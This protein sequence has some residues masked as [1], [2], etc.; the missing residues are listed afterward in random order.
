MKT[1]YTEGQPL[2]GNPYQYYKFGYG[3]GMKTLTYATKETMT[4]GLQGWV[5]WYH[6][7]V[8][9]DPVKD[10]AAQL[11]EFTIRQWDFQHKLN[12]NLP[13]NQAPLFNYD[14]SNVDSTMLPIALEATNVPLRDG[15]KVTP[16]TAFGWV[17][18]PHTVEQYQAAIAAFTSK[19][20]QNG[21][22]TYFGPNGLGWPTFYN[23]D[24]ASTGINI[25]AGANLFLLTPLGDHRSAYDQ[26]QF[27]LSSNGDKPVRVASIG[28]DHSTPDPD[29]GKN[30]SIIYFAQAQLDQL[31]LVK[32]GMIVVGTGGDT[33]PNTTVTKVDL[34]P[35]SNNFLEVTVDTR[36]KGLSSQVYDFFNP[37]EDYAATTLASLWYGWANY[38][39]TTHKDVAKLPDQPGSIAANSFTLTFTTPVDASK[40][41]VGMSVTGGSAWR[42]APRSWGSST[43]TT[44]TRRSSRSP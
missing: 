23:P 4:G 27:A 7:K 32:K 34:T 12:P 17:G 22:G 8:V 31:K 37:V 5:M 19:G 44:P 39:Y 16:P 3:Q 1:N 6:A 41:V 38:Y 2:T 26:N 15:Q 43:R 25:P 11:G 36:T 30:D 10:A 42:L 18:A 29:T 9:H 24:Q 21:L 40:L 20:A 28:G 33:P 35:D 14:M 13:T